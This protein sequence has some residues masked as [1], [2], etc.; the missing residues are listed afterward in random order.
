MADYQDNSHAPA[1]DSPDVEEKMSI[2]RYILTRIPTLVPPMRK[3][4]N[5]F[6]ALT[7]LNFQQ[8]MFFFVRLSCCFGPQKFSRI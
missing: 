5:P 6:T 7:L 4:P 8:W 2:G 3:A 1:G